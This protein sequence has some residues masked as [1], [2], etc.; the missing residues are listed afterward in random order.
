MPMNNA[1]FNLSL[2]I[3]KGLYKIY[4]LF[5]LLSE[6]KFETRTIEVVLLLWCLEFCE[7]FYKQFIF[8]FR[9][10]ILSI[11]RSIS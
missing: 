6:C 7:T 3:H 2:K 1:K 9:W 8:Y 11:L 5:D 4:R 10:P